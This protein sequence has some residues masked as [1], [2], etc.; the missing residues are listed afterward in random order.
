[1]ELYEIY[2]PNASLSF[3]GEV[4]TGNK[5]AL[6]SSSLTRH[7]HVAHK[8]DL[9][10]KADQVNDSLNSSILGEIKLKFKKKKVKYN[11]FSILFPF[12]FKMFFF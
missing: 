4:K 3:S 7:S 8:L 11:D 10:G 1:M 12:N 2:E 6:N 9:S 5:F